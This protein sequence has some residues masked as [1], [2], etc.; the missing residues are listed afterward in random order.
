MGDLE[1]KEWINVLGV[2]VKSPCDMPDDILKFAIDRAKEELKD[3][4]QVSQGK[5]QS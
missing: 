4:D 3:L 1:V 5:D 2:K